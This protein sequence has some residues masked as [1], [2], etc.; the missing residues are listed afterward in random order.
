MDTIHGAYVENSR[1][2]MAQ[3]TAVEEQIQTEIAHG[4]YVPVSTKPTIVS[5]LSA[6]PKSDATVRLIHDMSRPEGGAVNDMATK[7]PFQ[8]ESV[9]D[10]LSCVEP[11]WFMAKVDLQSAYRCVPLHPS[12]FKLTGLQWTFTGTDKPQY[13]YDCCLPFGARKSPAIFHRLTQAVKRMMVRKGFKSIVVYLDDFLVAGP[14]F[15]ECLVA[16]NTLIK[17]LRSLG[18]MISWTKVCDPCQRLTFLGVVIDTVAGIIALEDGRVHELQELL[19]DCSQRT[20]MSRRQLESVAGKLSWASNVIPWGRTHLRSL[21]DVISILKHP[22]HKAKLQPLYEDLQWWREWL[23]LGNNT[24]LIWDSRPISHVFT[25]SSD[26]AGGAFCLGDWY[27]SDWESDWPSL[28]N[29]HIN[30]K[31]L[32]AVYVAALRWA[33]LWTGTRVMVHTD[34]KVVEGILNKGSSRAPTSLCILKQLASLALVYNFNVV[35]VHIPGTQNII[36]DSLSRLYCPGQLDRFY[37]NVH[38][39]YSMNNMLPPTYV[40]S[41][42]MSHVSMLSILPQTRQLSS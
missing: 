23:T 10:A 15:Q 33:P 18:F 37:D 29:E 39:V 31:E 6:V 42:H 14:T 26:R 9:S 20:R 2:A 8:C 28:V 40:L 32:A 12:Q 21:F 17:L 35:A 27:F 1:S 34:S 38:N 13:F 4:R 36:P 30:V 25:D 22:S 7:D 3:P 16:Y 11:G 5:A 41:D 19:A 24:R